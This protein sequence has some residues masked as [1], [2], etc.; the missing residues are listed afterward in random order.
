MTDTG[1]DATEA[2]VS[3]IYSKWP[4][5]NAYPLLRALNVPPLIGNNGNGFS[6]PFYH[7]T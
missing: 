1:G 3:I 6:G 7:T 5:L 2:A 4:N